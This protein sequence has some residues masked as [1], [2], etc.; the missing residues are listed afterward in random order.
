MLTVGDARHVRRTTAAPSVNAAVNSTGPDGVALAGVRRRSRE[1]G[2]A[3]LTRPARRVYQGWR[4]SVATTLPLRWWT[5]SIAPGS[6][7]TSRIPSASSDGRQH[8]AVGAQHGPLGAV[9]QR[10]D[11]LDDALGGRVL[12]AQL[13]VDLGRPAG[14]V[15]VRPSRSAGTARSTRCAPRSRR[16]RRAAAPA[17]R[18]APRR[19]RPAAAA[20]RP[21]A[22]PRASAPCRAA[23]PPVRAYGVA[24]GA[25]RRGSRG[26][27]GRSAGSSRPSTAPTRRRRS[28]RWAGS[29]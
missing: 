17:A 11:E 28:R 10:V 18:P 21:C 2:R 7:S 8:R 14:R 16:R 12:L 20:G 24:A 13:V 9:E 27:G 26:R 22:S 29:R 5:T 6:S 4:T 1:H 25:P 15:D 3:P 23:A 19:A